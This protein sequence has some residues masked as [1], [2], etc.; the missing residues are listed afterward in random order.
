MRKLFIAL[1]IFST[2]VMST[3]CS[4]E[5]INTDSI[6]E[7]SIVDNSTTETSS[8]FKNLLDSYSASGYT[9]KG[10]RGESFDCVAYIENQNLGSLYPWKYKI[11]VHGI[12]NV[13]SYERLRQ[14]NLLYKIVSESGNITEDGECSTYITQFS[15]YAVFDIY[16]RNEDGH[17]VKDLQGFL[18]E[19]DFENKN[20]KYILVRTLDV[21]YDAIFNQIVKTADPEV[22]KN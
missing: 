9:I 4:V 21:G 12:L 6:G 7:N 3:S 10:Q 11:L 20:E 14:E 16:L 1:M 19:E 18:M 2:M 8:D 22:I 13:H 15:G 5:N 17:L